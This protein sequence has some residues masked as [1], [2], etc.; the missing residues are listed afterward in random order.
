MAPISDPHLCHIAELP[1]E[2][3]LAI[4]MQLRIERGFQA[5]KDAERDRVCRNTATTRSLYALALVCRKLNAIATPVLYQ[6]IVQA[7]HNLFIARLLRTLLHKPEL[8]SHVRYLELGTIWNLKSNPTLDLASV[9]QEKYR[10]L[11]V[12]THSQQPGFRS[13]SASASPADRQDWAARNVS[14]LTALLSLTS[15]LEDAAL[16]D[17]GAYHNARLPCIPRTE[18]LRRL[19]LRI[20]HKHD[21]H[22][23]RFFATP[24]NAPPGQLYPFLRFDA[25]KFSIYDLPLSTVRELHII[26]IDISLALVD[27]L[28]KACASLESF[29]CR[30]QWTEHIAPSHAVDLPRLWTSLQ[31]VRT[32]LTHL[33]IDTSESAW[34]VDMDRNVPALGSLSGFSALKYLEV[35]ELVLWGDDD[36]T[37]PSPLAAILPVSLETLVVKA[38]WDDDIEDAL[39]ELSGE[40]AV[41]LPVLKRLECTWRPAPRSVAGRLVDAFRRVGVDL[42]L[43]V[44]DDRVLD[45]TDPLSLQDSNDELRSRLT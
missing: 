33:T 11:L 42:V 5:D 38:E 32:S 24:P 43:D 41:C 21:E 3:L 14:P 30:W 15:H 39:R 44:E 19:W 23:V 20:P 13:L 4:A 18:R 31:R 22:G 17:R 7:Q 36:S 10:A 45:G 12:Q 34:R 40:C 25:R 2:L 9:D 35:A 16:T 1:D 8:G 37:D 29:T 27:D 26:D 28:V 6:C